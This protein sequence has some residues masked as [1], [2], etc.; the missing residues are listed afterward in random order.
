[1]TTILPPS[2]RG[3]F[4]GEPISMILSGHEIQQ[5]LGRDIQI[6]PFDARAKLNPNSYNLTVARRIDGL[7]R[8]RA[9]H[10]QGKSRAADADPGRGDRPEP[11]PALSG[12]YRRTDR[13][14]QS[15]A[16]NRRPI[17]GWPAG[18]CL[19]TSRPALAMLASA[20]YWT[21][22]M[23]AV[24]PVRIYPDIPICQIFYHEVTGQLS[25][26]RQQVPAQPRHP[27]EL[28]IRGTRPEPRKRPAIAAR[29]RSGT[30]ASS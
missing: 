30:I 27:T 4:V 12:P 21:L 17:L 29:F 6:D 25:E 22:E 16:A 3:N 1:M 8:G 5:R 14:A 24:Q 26:Y 19:S 11:Q 18:A 28:A 13:H 23:F 7:R 15:C 10:G 2:W 20:G 9:R